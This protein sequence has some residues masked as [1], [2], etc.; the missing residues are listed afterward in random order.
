MVGLV[1]T[2]GIYGALGYVTYFF[3]RPALIEV[4]HHGYAFRDHQRRTTGVEHGDP[5]LHVRL[6]RQP[7]GRLARTEFNVFLRFI[8]TPLAF[9]ITLVAAGWPPRGSSASGPARPGTA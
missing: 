8:T 3:A 6:R 1:I 5:V 4:W 7:A 9:M 2:L